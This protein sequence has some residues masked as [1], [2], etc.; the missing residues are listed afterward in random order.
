MTSHWEVVKPTRD[1]SDFLKMR[2]NYP[3]RRFSQVTVPHAL[4]CSIRERAPDRK[5]AGG[6]GG[7]RNFFGCYVIV[8][9]INHGMTK[10]QILADVHFWNQGLETLEVTI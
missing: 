10:C 7:T 8:L 6:A 3:R 9:L 5:K 1:T 2:L 4:F